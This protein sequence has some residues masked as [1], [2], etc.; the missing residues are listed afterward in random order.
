MCVGRITNIRAIIGVQC[1]TR[2]PQQ[3]QPNTRNTEDPT[4]KEVR[5]DS[6]DQR[7]GKRDAEEEQRKKLRGGRVCC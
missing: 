5:R 4:R 1:G 2:S 7:K 6:R 3:I